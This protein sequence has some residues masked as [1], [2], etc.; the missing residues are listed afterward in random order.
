MF[1]TEYLCFLDI[2]VSVFSGYLCFL[3]TCVSGYLCFFWISVFSG[4]L[5]F[6]DISVLISVFS[7][8]HVFWISVFYQCFPNI[9][10]SWIFVFW[11][12]MFYTVFFSHK[13]SS[14]TP[15]LLGRWN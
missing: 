11:I 6:L 5:C 4:Y 13:M 2:C 10:V 14:H 15:D 3:D 8:Y 7:E 9:C 12:S 1:Y